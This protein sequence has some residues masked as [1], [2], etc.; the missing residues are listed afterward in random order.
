[1]KNAAYLTVEIELLKKEVEEKDQQIDS[2][3]KQIDSKNLRIRHLEEILPVI[4]DRHISI[5]FAP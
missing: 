3:D 4:G 5:V 2:K 1:M